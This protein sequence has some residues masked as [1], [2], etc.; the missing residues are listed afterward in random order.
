MTTSFFDTTLPLSRKTVW[1]WAVV[2]ALLVASSVF[3]WSHAAV[4]PKVPN[5]VQEEGT[6]V[7]KTAIINAVVRHIRQVAEEDNL[8]NPQ[9]DELGVDVLHIAEQPCHFFTPLATDELGQPQA[10]AIEATSTL[11]RQF[12]H[13]AHIRV[14]LTHPGGERHTL[15]V[16]VRITLTKKVWVAKDNIKPGQ[17]LSAKN[18]VAQKRTLTH[19]LGRV[20]FADKPLTNQVARLLVLEGA[21]LKSSQMTMPLAVRSQSFVKIQMTATRGVR[22]LIEG[23]ALE[24]GHVGDLIRVRNKINPSRLYTA[25][26]IGP[27]RVTVKL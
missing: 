4:L 17:A 1:H 14:A 8:Y 11:N 13:Q 15:G 10:V 5:K 16:P 24:D 3:S 2:T 12:R 18:L 19:E 7:E 26:I 23:K 9:T 22:M 27:N 21:M 20:A 6:T 25:R